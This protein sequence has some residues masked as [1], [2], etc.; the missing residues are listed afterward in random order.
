MK[1]E[2][3]LYGTEHGTAQD[4][5]VQDRKR[6]SNSCVGVEQA[7]Q[8][9][10]HTHTHAHGAVQYSTYFCS[11][12]FVLLIDLHFAQSSHILQ[13]NIKREKERGRRKGGGEGERQEEIKWRLKVERGC[14]RWN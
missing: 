3:G 7:C 12:L 2:T 9:Y 13:S 1:C 4:S 11:V 6:D 10:T 14:E 8:P 5:T